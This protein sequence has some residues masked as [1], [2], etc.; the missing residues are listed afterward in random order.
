[1]TKLVVVSAGLTNP[2]STKLLADRLTA[3]TVEALDDVDVTHVELRGLE[4]AGARA[5]LRIERDGDAATV[6]DVQV[7][8]DLEVVIE[9]S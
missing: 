8:G 4:V 3:A 9:S 1:M 5:D 2:S 6:A 7:D